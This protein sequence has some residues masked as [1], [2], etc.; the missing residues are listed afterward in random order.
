M[1]CY[2]LCNCLLSNLELDKKYIT[3]VLMIFPQQSNAHKIA[4]DK[5]NM[6]LNMYAQIAEKNEII[7]TWLSLMSM[8]PSSFETIN[9]D[10]SK[11]P[12]EDE[13]FLKVCSS[14]KSQQ[15]AIVNSHERWINYKGKIIMYNSVQVTVYDKDEAIVELTPLSSN[16]I[17]NATNST[18][19][20]DSSKIEDSKNINK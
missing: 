8:K 20:T 18:V 17:I 14:T 5:S 16:T 10:V 3:D 15:K 7:A 4:L 11:E 1:A 19:A 9:V 13:V 2:T 6:I 12:S